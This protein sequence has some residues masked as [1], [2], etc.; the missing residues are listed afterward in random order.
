MNLESWRFN[1][2]F[3]TYFQ[4]KNQGGRPKLSLIIRQTILDIYVL[5]SI[6]TVDRH[7]GRDRAKL[8]K[9]EY[10]KFYKDLSLPSEVTLESE[11]NKRGVELVTVIKRVLTVTLKFAEKVV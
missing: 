5:N 11:T 3:L 6:L 10:V 9:T 1:R 7:N 8:R 4:Q 2:K